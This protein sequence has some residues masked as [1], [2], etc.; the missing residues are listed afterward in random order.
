[1]PIAMSIATQV[2]LAIALP[3]FLLTLAA[4]IRA[5]RKQSGSLR[6]Q[7]LAAQ[8]PY[9][10]SHRPQPRYVM[11]FL[12]PC[13]DEELVIGRTVHRLMTDTDATIIVIDDGSTDS[14]AAAARDAVGSR[15]DSDRLRVLTRRLP[16]A[17]LGKGAALNAGLQIV[18][19]DVA[20]RDIDAVSVIVCVMDADGQLSPDAVSGALASFD[21]PG[22]G[23]VQLVVRIRNRDKW[24]TQFQDVEFWTIS[25]TAQ[26]ARVA[27]GTVSLGGNGQ[28]T[29]LA[30]LTQV[31]GDVWSDSLTEDLDLGL[32]LY[33]AGWKVTTTAH[34]FVD[35]QGVESYR[36]LLRQRTRWYQGHMTCIRRVPQLCRSP[37]INELALAE[38]ISYLLVPWLLVLPW[39]IL[40]QWVLLAVVFGSDGG[41]IA[42][43]TGSPLA[44]GVALGLW[45]LFSFL[46][47]LVIG[48]TYARRTKS[49][50]LGRAVVLGHLMLAYNYIGYVAAWRGVGR[51]I[52]GRTGWTKTP[53]S[54]DVL[55]VAHA[56]SAA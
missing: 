37:K 9:S 21:D 15:T 13:L 41:V 45:Y 30:A 49:I 53:R 26:F 42:G 4:G 19:A 43:F 34:G 51:M 25:A 22:V 47:N 27:T 1:M 5:I 24:I 14:T 38:S 33:A 7:E 8:S 48:L 50:S 31:R 29:R 20:D 6:G 46:P 39:S 17:R 52:I 35:Q 2:L 16:N 36:T 23:G 32:R 11:Y 40:Q 55:P 44:R 54:T 18:R 10:G 3:Y 12:I 28:F 56:H